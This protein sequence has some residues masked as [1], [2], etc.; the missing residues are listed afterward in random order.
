VTATEWIILLWLSTPIWTEVPLVALPDL[1]H[2][3]VSGL[4]FIFGGARSVYNSGINDGTRT[5]LQPVL[6]KVLADENEKLF[7]EIMGLKNVTEL[8]YCR[9]IGSGFPAKVDTGKVTHG[10]GIVKGFLHRRVGEVEPMLHEMDAEHTFKT[11]RGSAC[12]FRLGIKG[13]YYLTE[14]A[15]GII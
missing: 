15:P 10:A 3:R 4:I 1:V 11:N 14:F 9:L 8:A 12:A 13:L 6:R 2:L 7:A 5:D